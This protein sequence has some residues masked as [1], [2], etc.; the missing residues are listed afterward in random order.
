M[1]MKKFLGDEI[2]LVRYKGDF[3]LQG[4]LRMI[5]S[6]I[7]NKDY[8]F[9]EP[10]HKAKIPELE[11]K[12]IGEKKV[13]AYYM[14]KLEVVIKFYDLRET[15]VQDEKG[16]TKKMNN[17]RFVIRIDG[18]IET[19]YST[20]WDENK[21]HHKSLLFKMYEALTDRE[22]KVKHAYSLVM[23]ATELRD[24]INSYLGMVASN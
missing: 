19:G 16:N 6:F 23:E 11:I 8:D 20:E 18:G 12:W 7:K 10:K 21:S 5:Y 15:E 13:T 22:F 2:G 1:P 24:R 4:L 9:Y 17:A 3:D 14:Y